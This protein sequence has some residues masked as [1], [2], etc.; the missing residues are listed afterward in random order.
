MQYHRHLL[1][2]KNKHLK[3]ILNIENKLTDAVISR[4]CEL[5]YAMIKRMLKIATLRATA[6]ALPQINERTAENKTQYN[7]Y[8]INSRGI[9][10]QG[11]TGSR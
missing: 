7:A 9:K 8:S 5:T 11:R 3:K 4:F 1:Q 6:K 2:C 10:S